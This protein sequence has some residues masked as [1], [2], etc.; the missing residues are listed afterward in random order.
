MKR[1][2]WNDLNPVQKAA[3]IAAA[4]VEFALLA[5]THF[6]LRRRPAAAINGSK[7]MW[8]VLSFINFLGPLAYFTWGRKRIAA[9]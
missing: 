5:A 3:I 7:R 8:M 6:D 9:Q 2:R 4:V 1:K